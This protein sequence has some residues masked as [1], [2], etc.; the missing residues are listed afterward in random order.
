[1]AIFFRNYETD[2]GTQK[3]DKIRSRIFFDNETR[4]KINTRRLQ[5]ELNEIVVYNEDF[6]R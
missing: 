4:G 3:R 2:N 6:V 1:M 5:H